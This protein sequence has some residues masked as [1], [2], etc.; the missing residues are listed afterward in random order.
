MNEQRLARISGLIYLAVAV[1]ALVASVP[2]QTLVVHG[3][4]A[5]TASNIV[6]S[7]WLFGGSI[8]AWVGVVIADAGVAITLYLLLAP[9]GRALS[10]AAATF[11]ILYAAILGAIVLDMSSAS[12]S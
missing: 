3:D 6:G 1:L 2:Q 9:T 5:A 11:R 12:S 4:P 10:L 8:V 7:T